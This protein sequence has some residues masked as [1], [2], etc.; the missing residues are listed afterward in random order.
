MS[1]T[2]DSYL[3]DV[4]RLVV[5]S[6]DHQQRLR[7][8]LQRHFDDAADHGETPSDVMRR[9][10]TPNEVAASFMEG[11]PLARAGFWERT[12]A[13][14]ADIGVFGC[15]VVP[16]LALWA[17]LAPLAEDAAAP[18]RFVAMGFGMLAGLA[19]IG[20][21]IL[22]FP[23]LEH[24]YGATFGKRA[25]RLRVV[26]EQG[27]A[28]GLG[29]AFLRRL[30]LYV[31]LI[32]IDALFIPFTADKQRAFDMVAKTLVVRDPGRPA[33]SRRLAALRRAL[34]GARRQL[35]PDRAGF[36][37]VAAIFSKTPQ[38]WGM[39]PSTSTRRHRS[40]GSRAAPARRSRRP[41]LP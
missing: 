30:S 21:A 5:A 11:V 9:L 25:L 37:P 10:G 36:L 17:F 19:L 24:L 32:V 3:R 39:G 22:Y 28:V 38:D 27:L 2:A 33:I 8:D 41:H 18:L 12:I 15:L 35:R 20:I 1:E 26:T 23:L 40:P 13:F 14:L 31:E 7:A 29:A 6:E 4:L 16:S 34:A